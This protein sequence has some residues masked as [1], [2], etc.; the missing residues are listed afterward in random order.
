M[1]FF[2]VSYPIK[3]CVTMK[4]AH[5]IFIGTN[6]SDKTYSLDT[7]C[8]YFSKTEKRY[9]KKYVHARTDVAP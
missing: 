8:E 5:F 9:M 1:T 6:A 3:W 4:A 7:I 2:F